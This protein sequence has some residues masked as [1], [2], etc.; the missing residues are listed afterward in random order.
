MT[1]DCA[2]SETTMPQLPHPHRSVPHQLDHEAVM[3]Y[4]RT[5]YIRPRWVRVIA[6]LAVLAASVVGLQYI[7]AS[8]ARFSPGALI[9]LLL[10][11]VSVGLVFFLIPTLS[12]RLI[13][14][15]FPDL[16]GPDHVT[17]CMVYLEHADP[18]TLDEIQALAGAEQ[19]ALQVITVLPN[20]VWAGLIAC[21]AL[22]DRIQ[23][24][25]WPGFLIV[26]TGATLVLLVST[27]ALTSVERTAANTV[28]SKT[29]IQLHSQRRRQETAVRD[30]VLLE[31][32]MASNGLQ[33][34]RPLTPSLHCPSNGSRSYSR[35]SS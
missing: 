24:T 3:Q 10:G 19:N 6:F 29:I 18:L 22:S 15:M 26:I 35:P 9:G 16:I 20:L 28:I 12:K 32:L 21:V 34:A 14:A 30:Q 25:T 13:E 5:R 17:A 1:S 4:L 33:P 23:W 7:R 11:I 27:S 2:N 31:A 8:T